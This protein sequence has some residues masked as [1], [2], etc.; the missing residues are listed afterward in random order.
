[1][2]V[3]LVAHLHWCRC[4]CAPPV[5]LA[6]CAEILLEL[7]MFHMCLLCHLQEHCLI[8]HNSQNMTTTVKFRLYTA[9]LHQ[10]GLSFLGN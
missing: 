7:W 3:R 8:K 2:A 6:L 9:L 4:G 5:N 10:K 1:M